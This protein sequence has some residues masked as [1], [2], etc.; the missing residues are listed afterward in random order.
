VIDGLVVV[1]KETGWTS[2]DVVAK[3]RRVYGQRKV[4]H[5]GTLDPDATGV[6]LVGLGRMTRLLRYLTDQTKTYVGEVVLG[7]QTD[8]L[9]ASGS[10]VAT[11]DP[12]T[13]TVEGLAAAAADLTGD[14][15]QVPP[16]VSAVKIDGKR[17]YQMAREGKEVERPARPVTVHRFAVAPALGGE[18]NVHPIEVECSSG[19]YIRTLA[20]DLGDAV[21]CGAHLRALRRTAIGSLT[22]DAARVIQLIESDPASAVIPL[23]AALPDLAAVTLDPDTAARVRN[24]AKLSAELFVSTGSAGPWRVH[25][26]DGTLLAVYEP[27]RGAAKPSVVIV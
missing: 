16:M 24:G 11:A 6:L 27:H 19:T 18:P 17:L 20:A 10:V 14:I 3:L 25:A 23:R 13:V 2:H 7:V 12:S 21:G 22:S 4:G 8:T 9:D 5:A 1:D 15:E 26:P